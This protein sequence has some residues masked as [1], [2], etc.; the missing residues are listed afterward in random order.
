MSETL[1]GKEPPC[2]H[3]EG[4]CCRQRDPSYQFAVL[5][6]NDEAGE[7][8]AKELISDEVLRARCIDP[9]ENRYA[10]PYVNGKCVHLGE[11]NKCEIYD[12]RPR[13]CMEF[14]C[15]SSY[16]ARGEHHGF[17]LEDHPRVAELIELH[18]LNTTLER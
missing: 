9:D 2:R 12:R 8:H 6:D 17:F 11:G 1:L 18:V 15:L 10:L 13:N 14:T 5:L 16:K 3:C 4:F 7:F